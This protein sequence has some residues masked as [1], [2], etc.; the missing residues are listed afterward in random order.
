MILSDEVYEFLTFEKK[1][2]PI[3]SLP[4]MRERVITLSSVGKTLSLTGWKIGWALAPA[5]I[6]KPIHHVHQ[7]ITFCVAT[8]LQEAIAQALPK[9]DN[10][11][12]E[13]KNDYQC[14]RDFLVAGL[15]KLH[16]E[17]MIPEGTYFA[18]A[19]VPGER[20]DDEFMR[21]LISEKKVAVIPVSGF[22]FRPDDNRKYLRFCFAKKESTLK[23]ALDNLGKV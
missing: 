14:K 2:I 8:P 1:H 17:I 10:Y 12:V 7:F 23:N 5:H 16:Y 19:K 15:K 18:L 13:F 22:Y 4:G 11:L 9:L 20:T 6:I 21:I 3:A